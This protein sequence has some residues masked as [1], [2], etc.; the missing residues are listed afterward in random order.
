MTF[1]PIDRKALFGSLDGADW[2]SDGSEPWGGGALSRRVLRGTQMATTLYELPP[3]A[4]GGLHHCHHGAEEMLVVLQGTI[5]LRTRDGERDIAPGDVALFPPGAQAAHQT[6]NR[7][8][9]PT[10]HLMIGTIATPDVVE[11]PDQGEV[12]V[13]ALTEG[14]TGAPLFDV[15]PATASR[16]RDEP[17]PD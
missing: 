13:M 3:G 4:T 7:T 15:F 6:I 9:A 2:D 10:R 11:Y 17:D 1:D 16:V 12:L 14:M 5:T 8:G